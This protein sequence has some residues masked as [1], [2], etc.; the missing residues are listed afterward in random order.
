MKNFP[1]FTQDPKVLSK[2]FIDHGNCK[3]TMETFVKINTRNGFHMATRRY[4][5]K[6][7]VKDSILNNKTGS[8]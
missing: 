8:A 4:A 2:A 3:V 7:S 1:Y 5:Q 6:Y